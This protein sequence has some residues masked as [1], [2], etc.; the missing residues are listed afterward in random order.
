M[1]RANRW[2][3]VREANPEQ[4]PWADPETLITLR[5]LSQ[6]SEVSQNS[7]RSCSFRTWIFLPGS[8]ESDSKSWNRSKILRQS[9]TCLEVVNAAS[10]SKASESIQ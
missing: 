1:N 9:G 8:H 10:V 3:A 7:F 2:K 4:E 6:V 5:V